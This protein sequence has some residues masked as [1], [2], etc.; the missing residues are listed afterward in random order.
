MDFDKIH[1]RHCI[2]HEFRLGHSVD[3]TVTNLCQ[4]EG[5]DV[6][7]RSTVDRWFIRFRQGDF[8]LEDK[9]KSGRPLSINV[10]EL[11]QLVEENPRQTTR[12]LA[13]QLGCTHATIEHHLHSLGKVA[14]LGSWVPHR[15][16]P[17]NLRDRVETCTILLSKSRRFD[18]LD[19]LITGDEKWVMYVN[20]TRKRQWI[21]IDAEPVPDPKQDL[22]PK[23]VLLSVWWSVQGIVHFE[24]LPDNA[25]VTAEVY[26]AQ[27]DNVKAALDRSHSGQRKVYLLHDN[28]RPHVAKLTCAKLMELG[29]E[30]LPHPPYSPDLAPTDF[31]LFRSLHNH[32]KEKQFDDRKAVEL[33]IMNYFASKTA[34]FYRDGIH[35]LPQR[36]RYVVDQ[37]GKYFDD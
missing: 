5:R 8:S 13:T 3:Q 35:S 11:L 23:K 24:L 2:L 6:V 9:P 14:K 4:A 32:L 19:D 30:L 31:H 16:T 36:W 37:D 33:D 1:L 26:C 12:C 21:D 15:L 29:W 10:D 20:H 28:A 22:H 7:S 34:V 17:Q 25:T 18:W 27:L